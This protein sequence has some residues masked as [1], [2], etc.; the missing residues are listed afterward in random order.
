MLP[1][2]PYEFGESDRRFFEGLDFP[3]GKR[4]RVEFVDGKDL[5]WPGSR[6]VAALSRMRDRVAE[7]AAC[8][9]DD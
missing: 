6:S 2:E 5:F 7:L 4:P 8:V 9:Q 3:E 1:D